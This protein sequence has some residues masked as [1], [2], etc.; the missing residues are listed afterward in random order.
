MRNLLWIVPVLFLLCPATLP[1]EEDHSAA[2][3]SLRVLDVSKSAATRE[4]LYA[5]FRIIEDLGDFLV[6]RPAASDTAMAKKWCISS[7]LISVTGEVYVISL[8]G[9]PVS[10]IADAGTVLYVQGDIALA[11]LTPDAAVGLRRPVV[12]YGLEEGLRLLSLKRVAPMRSFVP[13]SECQAGLRGPDPRIASMVSQVNETNLQN[14]V[15]DMQNMVERRAGSGDAQAMAYLV[16]K[17]N[18]IPGLTVTTHH[19]SSSYADNVIA[20]LP[21]VVDPSVIYVVGGHYDSTSYSGSAPGAD[22]NASGTSAVIEIARILSQYQFK[23]TIRFCAF[24]AEELG[25]IGSR[26]YCDYLLQQGDNVQAMINQDMNCYRG[27]GEPRDVGFITNYSSSSLIN[28]CSSM[29]ATYVPTLGVQQGSMSGGT[30]DHQSF[31][32]NGFT[33]CFPFEDI[34]NYSPY[35]HTSDD[36]IGVSANDFTLARMIT[37]GVLASLATL[38]APLDLEITHTELA[39]TMDASGPYAVQTDVASLIGSTVT[40]VTLFYDIGNGFQSKDMAYSGLGDNYVSSIPGLMAGAGTVKYYIEAEDSLGYTERLPDGLGSTS[41]E[42]VVG[43]FQDIF[44]D[45]FEINDNGWTHSGTGQDDWMRD[46]CS[47]N[48]GYDPSYAAS[49]TKVWGNDLG[50]S[51]YNGTYQSNVN[52][53]LQSK[54]F[55]CAGY[56]GVHLRYRRWLT[57]ERGIYDQAKVLVNGTEVWA[58]DLNTDHNDTEWALHEIDVSALADNNPNVSLKYTLTTNGSGVRGGWNIDDLHVG[59]PVSGTLAELYASEVYLPAS[60]G[61]VVTLSLNGAPS[62]AGRTY[63]TALSLSGTAPGTP[64]GSV[65]IPLN[66]DAYTDYC[67]QNLNGPVFKNF[68]GTLNGSGDATATFNAP[69]LAN[70]ILIGK[71]ISF[72]WFTLAPIDFASNP[73]EVLIVP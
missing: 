53:Y 22:D 25:L 31:T 43:G 73:V 47:G 3:T 33:A 62:Q 65:T 24:G 51:G 40:R 71:K 38:A 37:E 19:F 66:K 15:Q 49:G 12:H 8:R 55:S 14:V 45:D 1:A 27:A 61:G 39:D 32:E 59:I 56:T 50:I 21:G 7:R 68:A 35:I 2:Q 26:A 29:Y 20:E 36:V 41:F 46:V 28:F 52:N 18:Q 17:F 54:T 57:V 11:A 16:N 6:A 64:A 4:T 72:A 9:L 30:S 67:L 60:T 42:F 13:H 34:S 63:V 70:P 5:D 69:V 44:A 58:N 23:Y 48:G 10:K